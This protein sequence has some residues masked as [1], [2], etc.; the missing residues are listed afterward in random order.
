MMS[1]AM[2]SLAMM[3]WHEES[4][5]IPAKGSQVREVYATLCTKNNLCAGRR[6]WWSSAS[7]SAHPWEPGW[8][9]STSES[10]KA[11]RRMSQTKLY[12]KTNSLL[13]IQ[14]MWPLLTLDLFWYMKFVLLIETASNDQA[15]W[16]NQASHQT[17]KR[18]T[19]VCG[20][21][22]ICHH[23]NKWESSDLG[24]KFGVAGFSQI[25]NDQI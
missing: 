23:V 1:L 21:I 22:Y 8:A 16:L 4:S 5:W 13:V 10:C 7:W 17:V 12:L 15:A 24:F 20:H 9:S 19:K 14:N 18:L 3:C 2:M 25:L 11:G 6:S